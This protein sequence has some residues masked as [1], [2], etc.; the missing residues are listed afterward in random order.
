MLDMLECNV[1]FFENKEKKRDISNQ[2]FAIN[3]SLMPMNDSECVKT[4][5]SV[6]SVDAE[7][8]FRS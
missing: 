8:L 2:W 6:F 4:I 5:P 1:Y 3:N 7:S